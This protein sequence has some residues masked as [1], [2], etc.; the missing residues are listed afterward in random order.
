MADAR[1]VCIANLSLKRGSADHLIRRTHTGLSTIYAIQP[2]FIA[3]ATAKMT[4]A[5]IISLS[6]WQSQAEAEKA[7]QTTATW[8]DESAAQV[9]ESAQYHIGELA[10]FFAMRGLL[11]GGRSQATVLG[12]TP[13]LPAVIALPGTQEPPADRP[14]E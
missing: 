1:Y 10:A 5:C 13:T 7:A 6:V 8:L 11:T 2:G 12:T 9:M 3:F 4:N 14:A